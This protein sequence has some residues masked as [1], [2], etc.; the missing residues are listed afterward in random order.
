MPWWTDLHGKDLHAD[1]SGPQLAEHKE[2]CECER[3]AVV[4]MIIENPEDLLEANVG[5]IPQRAK[6]G[7]ICEAWLTSTQD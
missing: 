6:S 3:A 1:D 2:H 7:H 5:Q 4:D